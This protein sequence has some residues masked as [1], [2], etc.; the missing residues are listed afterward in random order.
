MSSLLR[1]NKTYA[2]IKEHIWIEA[3]S[4]FRLRVAFNI[5]ARISKLQLMTKGVVVI[6]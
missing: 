2:R 4:R 3:A 1:K 6:F 5:A